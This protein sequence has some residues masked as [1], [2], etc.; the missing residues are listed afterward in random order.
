[1]SEVRRLTLIP[2]H[3]REKERLAADRERQALVGYVDQKEFE[4][5]AEQ[6]VW[7][8]LLDLL[9]LR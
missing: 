9:M 1:V 5:G 4:A 8:T 2:K 6:S 7:R 3:D